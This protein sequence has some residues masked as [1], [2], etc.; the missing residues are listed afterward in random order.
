MGRLPE[1]D[2]R[3]GANKKPGRFSWRPSNA[4]IAVI[5]I[6]I[7]TVGP[8]LAFTKHVPFTGYGYEVN[9]TF[10]N[11]VNISTNSPVRIAGVDVG[12]VIA[13]GRDG[14]ATKVTFTVEDKGRPIHEDAFAQIRP[15]I[16]SRASWFSRPNSISELS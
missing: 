10:A 4:M 8:Y 3:A 7:F 14:D 2:T 11:G 13:V 15:R 6:L 9:A 1:R 12:R 5:F 16:W